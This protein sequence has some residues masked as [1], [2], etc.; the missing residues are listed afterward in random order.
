MVERNSQNSIGLSGISKVSRVFLENNRFL[1]KFLR[2]FLYQ[3]QDIEDV[4]QETYIKA[5]SAEQYKDI[6]HPKA[7]LFSIAKNLALNE[8]DRKSRQMT[9]SIE[10]CEAANVAQGVENL[11]EEVQAQQS[12]TLYCQ[13][14][15]ALPKRCRQVYLLRKV[16]GLS[17]KEI[18]ARLG[19]SLSA[20]AK[21]LKNGVMSCHKHIKKANTQASPMLSVRRQQVSGVLVH[22]E[23]MQ[24]K[25][26]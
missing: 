12:V 17:H 16:H 21:H 6:E 11:E 1:K 19:I 8:L 9:D 2:R 25:E 26:E 23:P 20:V 24:S 3:V 5:C 4:V 22:P 15:A 14:V 10:E 13:A 18:A 7:F